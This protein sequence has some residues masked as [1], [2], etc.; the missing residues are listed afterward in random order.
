MTTRVSP[1]AYRTLLQKCADRGCS[2]YDYLRWLV[3]ADVGLNADG[4]VP[5]E[6]EPVQTELIDEDERVER[7]IRITG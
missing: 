5:A 4:D 1:E 3:H 7:G 6:E 2:T